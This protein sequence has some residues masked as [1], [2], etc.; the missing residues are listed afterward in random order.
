VDIAGNPNDLGPETALTYNVG[1]IFNFGGFNFSVDYWSFD[2]E[3]E[4]TTTDAQAL[5]SSVVS[6]FTD[7]N[8]DA[9]T[10][11]FADCT[12][13][14]AGAI[15]FDGGCVPNMTVGTD[16]SRVRTQWVNGPDTKTTGLD[17]QVT[18]NTSI[19]TGDLTV[20]ANATHVLTYD[21]GDFNLN[22]V[23]LRAGFEA[24]GLANLDR[25][26][27]TIAPWRGNAYIN[28]NISG[29]NARYGVQYVDGVR[30]ERCPALPA[31][32]ATTSFGGTNFGRNI[33]SYTQHDAHFAYDLPIDSMDVQLQL[34]VENFTNE[35]APSAR[36]PLG[37]NPFTGNPLG[38]VWRLGAKVGF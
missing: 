38:R 14:F 12:S 5:A 32:C 10:T 22:G 2:F 34:S 31:P 30:D 24:V 37:Y 21:V 19:G 18:Y 33:A 26:P 23:L 15:I 16:I 17:F 35:D 11:P 7:M 6:D 29:F 25:S 1:A 13:P 27:G 28:Y 20:G 3:G 9:V 36:V 8:G 4:I